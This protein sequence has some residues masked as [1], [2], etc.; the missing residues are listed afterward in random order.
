MLRK[1]EPAASASKAE[2]PEDLASAAAARRREPMPM[3][4]QS[5]R[6]DLTGKNVLVTGASRG[7]GQA[8]ALAFARLGSNVAC[9][10]TNES[11]AH[12]AAEA[13]SAAAREARTHHQNARVRL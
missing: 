7:I 3:E 1:I 12:A 4:N 8:I 10:A 2:T 11:N 6:S 5:Q 9:V 13:C